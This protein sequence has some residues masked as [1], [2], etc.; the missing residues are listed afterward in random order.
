M[1][2]PT[3]NA[4]ASSSVSSRWQVVLAA[5]ALA[6]W[7]LLIAAPTALLFLVLW[8][9]V[10]V[11][12]AAG[13]LDA[14]GGMDPQGFAAAVDL[15]GKVMVFASGA[16]FAGKLVEFR[17][18]R[19]NAVAMSSAPHVPWLFWQSFVGLGCAL[20]IVDL[21]LLPLAYAGV[22]EVPRS[23]RGAGVIGGAATLLVLASWA[24]F[25][26]W[27]RAMRALWAGARSSSFFAGILTACGLIAGLSAYALG[28]AVVVP[29]LFPAA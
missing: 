25:N 6:V 9:A 23:I 16:A 21:V 12:A 19:S 22:V 15:T 1:T 14:T 20:L 17:Q 10:L 26:A 11:V 28:S 3:S 7:S 4:S 24:L 8:A 27:W 18:R 13:L 5:I 2:T 29:L